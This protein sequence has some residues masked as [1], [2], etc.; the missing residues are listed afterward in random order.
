MIVVYPFST[1][2]QD[3]ALKNA[4]WMNEIGGCKGHQV[5]MGYD[6]RCQPHIVKAVQE[7]LTKAFDKVYPLE[8]P[9]EIDGWP[10][11]ANYFFRFVAAR[12]ETRPGTS[13]FFW[14]EPDAIPLK[15]GWLDA[16]AAEYVRCG[17]KFMGDR[18]QVENIPLH[19]S[20]VGVYPLPL[21]QFSGEAYRAHDIAWD[22]AGREQIVPQAYFTK[23]IEHAWKHPRFTSIDELRTQIRPEAVLFHSS[24][25]G[26]LIDLL[27]VSRGGKSL[28]DEPLV[29]SGS[30]APVTCDIF[31]RTYPKDYEWL[32]Y[33]LKSIEKFCTGFHKIMVVSP[34][35]APL[36]IQLG[37]KNWKMPIEWKVV[38]D[39]TEDGYLAQ[40]ITKLYADVHL[41]YQPDYILHV[42]SD[43]IFTR[44]TTPQDFFGI[45]N[46]PVWYYT[47]Y[48]EIQTPW[49]PITEKFMGRRI[50]N[51]FMRRFPILIPRWLYPRVREFCNKQHG[52]IIS[53][54][55]R[56]QPMRAFSE[57]NVLGA[58]A[59]EFHRSMFDFVNTIKVNMPAPVAK[60][61]HSWGGITPEIK[62]EI[63]N[64]L[65]GTEV[66]TAGDGREPP[67]PVPGTTDPVPPQIK[68]LPNGLWVIDGDTHIS[69]WIEQQ[70][71]LD[72]D[73]NLLPF[74]LPHL[75][76]GDVVID[77]G[78]F[79]GDHTIAYS[80]AVGATGVVHAFEP[81]PVAYTCL[82]HNMNTCG[83]VV[84]HNAGLSD[85]ADVVP[86][87]GN[88][89]NYGGCYAGE[90]MKIAD[91]SMQTLDEVFGDAAWVDFIKLDIEGCEAHALR[92]A[93]KLITRFHPKMVIEVNVEA[94]G[95]QGSYPGEIFNFLKEH[96]YEWEILQ[97]NC[98]RVS[99][100]YDIL[101]RTK[102]SPEESAAKPKALTTT[103]QPPVTASP[104]ERMT[105]CVKMIKEFADESP[106]NRML[107]MQRLGYAG[108][109][110]KPRVRRKK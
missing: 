68:K 3:L 53:Q 13:E 102:K 74:I 93:E 48:S 71:R 65:R 106:R 70:Q 10:E 11:G 87:S 101:C 66:S 94:L 24:K 16:L 110:K 31:I 109:V 52:M 32:D 54:Y 96:G 17:R 20:G 7:E 39:E 81:N 50:E 35:I 99:P 86:L 58:Y 29:V 26:S 92:G 91:V 61:Y 75:K 37:Y 4:Q 2:D 30:P 63:E 104:S 72:H 60:Q 100:M 21:H 49:Q 42:D 103:P 9:A 62:T 28:V 55:I 51:E 107:T 57:F 6:K 77:A 64:T 80:K 22:M 23:L 44:P 46:L 98:N 43:V 73:Q 82:Q 108:L 56:N 95:R 15:E 19:M 59:W 79:V 78:A 41:D 84:M 85:R 36:N 12:L 33:C 34:D 5:L 67:S 27:R 1:V 97:E 88:N 40:Q 83:N 47:P 8:F 14:L 90:H 76:E 18:V 105:E 45:A 25:D 38:Q 69:K 89:G